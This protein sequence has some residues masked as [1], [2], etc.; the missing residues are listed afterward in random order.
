MTIFRDGCKRSGI[1]INEKPSKEKK[2]DN[3]SINIDKKE[4]TKIENVKIL[5]QNYKLVVQYK[6]VKMPELKIENKEIQVIR[7]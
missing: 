3:K 2:S 1:L 4:N 6:S 5:G 7:R